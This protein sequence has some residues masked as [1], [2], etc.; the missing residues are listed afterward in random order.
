MYPKEEVYFVIIL[1][2][3]PTGSQA[4][5]IYFT[6]VNSFHL[7]NNHEGGTINNPLLQMRKPGHRDAR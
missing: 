7:H 5:C 2:K 3:T 4:F 6:N 1:R